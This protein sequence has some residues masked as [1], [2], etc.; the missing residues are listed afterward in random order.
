MF[1]GR[2]KARALIWLYGLLGA[3]AIK[4]RYKE[5]I[6]HVRLA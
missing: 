5:V 3:V 6:Q 4:A 2:Y 1:M